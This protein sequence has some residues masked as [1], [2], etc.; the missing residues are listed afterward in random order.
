MVS[1]ADFAGVFDDTGG[2]GDIAVIGGAQVPGNF[3][4]EF[5]L[6]DNVESQVPVFLCY[7]SAVRGVTNGDSVQ[8]AGD[9]FRVK[10]VRPGSSRIF[11]RLVLDCAS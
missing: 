3:Q 10:S 2:V 11:T 9:T 1:A 8:V 7:A 5:M 4:S 6:V